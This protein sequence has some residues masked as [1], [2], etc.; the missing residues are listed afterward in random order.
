MSIND[1]GHKPAFGDRVREFMCRHCRKQVSAM[2]FGT[3]NRNHCP[4]CLHSLH[5]DRNIGDRMS[6]CRGIMEPIAVSVRKKGEWEIIHRC[7]ECGMIRIN[8]IAGDDNEATLISLALRPI[9]NL[10]FPIETLEMF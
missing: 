6:A 4:Y 7:R 8:R 10:P 5:V 2:S 1:C 9:V 3:M